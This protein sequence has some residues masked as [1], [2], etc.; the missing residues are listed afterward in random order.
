MLRQRLYK[1]KIKPIMPYLIPV[2]DLFFAVYT[3]DTLFPPKV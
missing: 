1:A 2:I 3:Y